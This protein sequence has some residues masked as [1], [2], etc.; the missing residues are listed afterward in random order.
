MRTSAGADKEPG[1]KVTNNIESLQPDLPSRVVNGQRAPAPSGKA[2][3]GTDQVQLS[4]TSRTLKAGMS[5]ENDGETIRPDKVEEI[6]EAIKKGEFHVSAEVVADKMI[7]E[8]A[9]LVEVM[10]AMG[11]QAR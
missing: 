1:M 6:R 10:T 3:E 4:E 8:A 5:A 11:Q 2:A 7:A 9:E